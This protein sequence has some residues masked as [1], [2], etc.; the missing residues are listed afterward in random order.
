MFC[1]SWLSRACIATCLITPV[2]VSS[3]MRAQEPLAGGGE[4]DPFTKKTPSKKIDIEQVLAHRISYDLNSDQSTVG[5]LFE[6][7]RG[8]IQ[9]VN[10]VI[11]SE[12][13]RVRLP[14]L[15]FENLS[16][17][18]VFVLLNK[19]TNDRIEVD[20]DTIHQ[21]AEDENLVIMV[22]CHET[23]DSQ[24]TQ[25]LSVKQLLTGGMD[26]TTLMEAFDGGLEFL[27]T[28]QKP[29]I[30]FQEK[31]GLLFVRGTPMQTNFLM[32]MVQAMQGIPTYGGG[33]MGGMGG[34]GGG[35]MGGMGGGMG[36]MGGGFGGS[37][38]GGFPG[39]AGGYGGGGFPGNAGGM[40]PGFGAGGS[41]GP[42]P[43]GGLTAPGEGISGGGGT[44]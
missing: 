24:Q 22:V 25:V 6:Q 21:T 23:E 17:A 10:F 36:G 26:T 18:T 16:A 28:D 44:N 4:Q 39:G 41:R 31:T 38:G 35:G 30:R 13:S 33:M 29:E 15:K 42:T 9:N 14:D 12:A 32:E 43:G 3:P 20:Y 11:S 40:P 34:M 8:Q 27:G 1:K 7:L 19:I 2:G 5:A 37:P